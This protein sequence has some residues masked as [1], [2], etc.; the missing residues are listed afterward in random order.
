VLAVPVAARLRRKGLVGGVLLVLGVNF[1]RLVGLMAVGVLPH[2]HVDVS[3]R[4]VGEWLTIL[5]VFVYWVPWAR[6]V[7]SAEGVEQAR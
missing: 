2:R 3:H 6:W 1:A 4:V 5:T 7:V